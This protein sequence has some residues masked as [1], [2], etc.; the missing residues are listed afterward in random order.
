MKISSLTCC[1]IENRGR[2][3]VGVISDNQNLTFVDAF[4]HLIQHNKD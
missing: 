4:Q 2:L 3:Y 1:K